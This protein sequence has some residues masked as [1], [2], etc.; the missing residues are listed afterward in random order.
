MGVHDSYRE[1]LTLLSRTAKKNK[2]EGR[3]ILMES[4]GLAMA[5]VCY[6]GINQVNLQYTNSIQFNSILFVYP[7]IT[8]LTQEH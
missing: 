8:P 2:G 6:G 4:L 5:E 3:V 1:T 7:L